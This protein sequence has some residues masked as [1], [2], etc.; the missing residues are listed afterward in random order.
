M[1][2]WLLLAGAA[3]AQE[4]AGGVAA[5]PS[6]VAL[7]ERLLDGDGE[8]RAGALEALLEARPDL[9]PLRGRLRQ[10]V[11]RELPSARAV[12][13]WTAEIRVAGRTDLA[14]LAGELDSPD[15]EERRRAIEQAGRC[16]EE[17]AGLQ[18]RVLELAGDEREAVQVA[19]AKNAGLLGWNVA[20]LAV[21]R[22]LLKSENAFV[23]RA[24]A[25]GFAHGQDD[26][27]AVAALRG[28]LHDPDLDVRA[29]ALQSL[30]RLGAVAQPA[31]L[32]IAGMM[33]DRQAR[34]RT[35]AL[36]AAC[37]LG[38]RSGHVADGTRRC[39]LEDDPKVLC[40]AL[41]C[42]ALQGESMSGS[43]DRVRE[44]TGARREEVRLGAYR[45]MWA[46]AGAARRGEAALRTV[47]G[48]L[49]RGLEGPLFALLEEQCR[50]RG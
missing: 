3:G 47:E 46:V 14:R 13:R 45:A 32:E 20:V 5:A 2:C 24:A 4:G 19:V 40:A 16:G 50:R 29:R 6:P 28:V 49:D 30:G 21:L 36:D 11:V 39:L 41:R 43:F 35:A 44:L 1:P 7:A 23:R 37:E 17:A 25:E 33:R 27:A 42:A 9:A 18:P 31:S 15:S 12:G 8:E 26:P 48:L 34:V 22:Q 10:L 38:I